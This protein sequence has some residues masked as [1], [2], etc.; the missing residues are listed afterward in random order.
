MSLKQLYGE[1]VK[2]ISAGFSW[3]I[4]SFAKSAPAMTSCCDY[5]GFHG[6]QKLNQDWKGFYR[7]F[8]SICYGQKKP[9][10]YTELSRGYG[11]DNVSEDQWVK[12]NVELI[13]FVSRPG[14]IICYYQVQN[15]NNSTNGKAA[16][17]DANFNATKFMKAI[18]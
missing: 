8:Q 11:R 10:A 5:F 4:E 15:N 1:R 16:L 14:D 12:D 6:Y 3:D 17:I 13:D 18:Q 2:V 7:R 9:A